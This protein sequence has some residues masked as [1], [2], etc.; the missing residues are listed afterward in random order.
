MPPTLDRLLAKLQRQ[1]LDRSLDAVT[2]DVGHRL[3]DTANANAATWR[4]RAAAILL[5]AM[6]GAV[7]SA[8]TALI[9]APESASLFEV[10]SNLAPS[11]LL[12]SAG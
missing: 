7:A 12:E 3:A 6:G 10:W 5:V 4:L 2:S 1:P 8:S 11:T 9:A